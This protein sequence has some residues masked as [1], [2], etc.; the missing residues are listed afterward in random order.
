MPKIPSMYHLTWIWRV[1]LYLNNMYLKTLFIKSFR[2]FCTIRF[3]GEWCFYIS[4]PYPWFYKSMSNAAYIYTTHPNRT[5]LQYILCSPFLGY[6]NQRHH[7]HFPQGVSPPYDPI[8]YS[9]LYKLLLYQHPVCTAILDIVDK[10]KLREQQ[11]P[12]Y[13]P[14]P[15]W[16]NLP[17]I[18][19][20]GGR[21][22]RMENNKV[23]SYKHILHVQI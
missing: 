14:I 9:Y 20:Y 1:L 17:Q 6:T 10:I 13:N 8:F 7:T 18:A 2:A 5:S 19:L 21:N 12:V 22:L 15:Q 4:A 3:F 11:R 23:H 16:N